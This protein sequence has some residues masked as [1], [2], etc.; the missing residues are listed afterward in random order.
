MMRVSARSAKQLTTLRCPLPPRLPLQPGMEL[1]ASIVGVMLQVVA[2]TVLFQL[3]FLDPNTLGSPTI[4]TWVGTAMQLGFFLTIRFNL[5]GD[6]K[7][8]EAERRGMQHVGALERELASPGAGERA[9]DEDE[10]QGL[11]PSFTLPSD[12]VV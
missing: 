7:R 1:E 2:L 6:L 5:V 3:Y 11:R 12:Q 9:L 4:A 8:L 10:R